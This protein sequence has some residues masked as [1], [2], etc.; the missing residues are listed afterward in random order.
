MDYRG[1]EGLEFG[2]GNT[3]VDP[4]VAAGQISYSLRSLEISLTLAKNYRNTAESYPLKA[5]ASAFGPTPAVSM[6]NFAT[7]RRSHSLSK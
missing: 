5:T 7:G 6:S 1:A 2:G 3:K 4:S